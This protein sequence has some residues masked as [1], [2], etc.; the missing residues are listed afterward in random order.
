MFE[1]S[2]K[3]TLFLQIARKNHLVVT[4]IKKCND[5]FIIGARIPA[6]IRQPVSFKITI[7]FFDEKNRSF[8]FR[9][10]YRDELEEYEKLRES[11]KIQED[12]IWIRLTRYEKHANNPLAKKKVVC[13]LCDDRVMERASIVNHILGR[14]WKIFP[15]KC[16][17]CTGE[18]KKQ[19]VSFSSLQDHIDCAHL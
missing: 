19:Y 3:Y 15:F 14:H 16:A 5:N 11:V 4:Y 18:T 8:N 6:N 12:N 10:V 1:I 7:P 9:D 2:N 17:Y 13:K